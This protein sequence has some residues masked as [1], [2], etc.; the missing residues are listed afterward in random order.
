MGHMGII[1]NQKGLDVIRNI[2]MK[3]LMGNLEDI[4]EDIMEKHGVY[5][6]KISEFPKNEYVC[7]PQMG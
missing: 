3:L 1:G 6:V 4:M 2:C 5:R 7:N